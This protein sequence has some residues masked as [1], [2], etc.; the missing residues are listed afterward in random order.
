M[1][2][3]DPDDGLEVIPSPVDPDYECV[4]R[5][6]QDPTGQVAEPPSEQPR[7]ATL[8]TLC[9][10]GYVPRRRRRHYTL[11]GKRVQTGRPPERN[12]NPP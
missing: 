1:P 8:P 3:D 6:L 2:V 12:P 4:R 11:D 5:D 7:E 9:P 10:E